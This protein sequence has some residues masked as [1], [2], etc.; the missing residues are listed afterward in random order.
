MDYFMPTI[1]IHP[2]AMT[3]AAPYN[4]GFIK[5]AGELGGVFR[6]AKWNFSNREELEVRKA[7][8]HFFGYDGLTDPIKVDVRVLFHR[9]VTS[10]EKR[11]VDILA[12]PIARVTDRGGDPLIAPGTIKTKG[13]IL[14]SGTKVRIAKDTELV[15]R[16]VPFSLLKNHIKTP[17]YSLEA[18]EID[19]HALEVLFYEY[20]QLIERVNEIKSVLELSKIDLEEFL[21]V[22]RQRKEERIVKAVLMGE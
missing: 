4:L 6:N 22:L 5:R 19:D 8:E 3:V 18:L 15:L 16:S 1:S 7:C 10:L 21:R 12:R 9:E 14:A 17:E 11:S 20:D 2:D 13:S